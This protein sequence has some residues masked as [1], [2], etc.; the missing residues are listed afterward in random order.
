[1]TDC[2]QCDMG[3]WF[4]A[5]RTASIMCRNC[6]GTGKLAESAIFILDLIAKLARLLT[7]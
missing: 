3:R 1:M 4:N 5:K 7:R 6:N 2:N